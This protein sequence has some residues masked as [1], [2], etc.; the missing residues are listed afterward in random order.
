MP[1]LPFDVIV[2]VKKTDSFSALRDELIGLAVEEPDE[3]GGDEEIVDF[4]W[5]FD[6]LKEAE[7]VAE[8]LTAVRRRPEIILLRLSNSDAPETSV[9][10]KDECDVRH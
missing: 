2:W 5:R 7:S 1:R 8:V 4:H 9:T 3:S 10:F 6:D